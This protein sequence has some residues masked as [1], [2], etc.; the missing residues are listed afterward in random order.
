MMKKGGP[1]KFAAVLFELDGTLLDTLED[2]ALTMNR[3]LRRRGLRAHKVEAYRELV[4]DGIEKMVRRALGAASVEES[5]IKEIVKEYRKEYEASWRN[6]S[7]PYPG[8]PEVLD[9]LKTRGIRLAVLSNKLH[10]FTFMMT[11]ELL[12][13]VEFDAVRGAEPDIP[14]KP[15]PV[16][17]L[18]IAEELKIAPSS[19]IFL[20][21][22]EV[23]MRTA[24]R[25]GMFPVGALWGFHGAEELE[26]NGALALLYSPSD[27]LKIIRGHN[28]QFT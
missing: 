27:L 25:A 1:D 5:V 7:K 9:E 20:G 22:S 17:A 11:T 26:K 10:R 15:D 16:A 24:K 3:I 6:N 18:L 19:F 8:I 2:I 4:G 14:L 12:P 28:T 13:G 21:D 23:D